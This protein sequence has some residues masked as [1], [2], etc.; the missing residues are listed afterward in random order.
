MKCQRA[1]GA[2]RLWNSKQA[3]GAGLPS[4]PC[5]RPEVSLD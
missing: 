4:P 5:V 2:Q 1:V 3:L